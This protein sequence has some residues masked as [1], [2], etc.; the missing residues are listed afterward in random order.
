MTLHIDFRQPSYLDSISNT[1]P[2]SRPKLLGDGVSIQA[3]SKLV[4][5]NEFALT[6]CKLYLVI[7]YIF[8]N[9]YFN[10]N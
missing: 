5:S 10:V 9:I 7:I 6:K 8:L 2:S 4:Q 1:T 3:Y